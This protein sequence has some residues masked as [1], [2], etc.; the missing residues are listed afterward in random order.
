VTSVKRVALIAHPRV[1]LLIPLALAIG[2]IATGCG[3]D[4]SGETSTHSVSIPAVTSPVPTATTTPASTTTPSVTTQGTQTFN[5]N[6]PD[7]ATND[8]PPKK[9]SPQDTFEQQCKQNP[10]ACG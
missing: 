5:P 1:T 10:D 8:V 4:S 7:S 3:S 6:A 9:G 2:L